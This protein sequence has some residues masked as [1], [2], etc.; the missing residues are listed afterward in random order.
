MSKY[1]SLSHRVKSSS[2]GLNLFWKL[3]RHVTSQLRHAGFQRRLSME[4]PNRTPKSKPRSQS[5]QRHKSSLRCLVE[6]AIHA[7]LSA[8]TSDPKGVGATTH[9][10]AIELSKREGLREELEHIGEVIRWLVR[11]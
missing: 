10:K 9:Q 7:P 4:R 3:H 8:E 11:S 2:F 1:P 6:P 5:S